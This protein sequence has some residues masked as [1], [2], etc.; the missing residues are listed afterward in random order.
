[1]CF[2]SSLEE[3]P[4]DEDKDDDASDEASSPTLVLDLYDDCAFGAI[5]PCVA[6]FGFTGLVVADASAEWCFWCWSR[7]S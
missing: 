1:M 4:S 5:I 6:E 2:S 3:S 7:C